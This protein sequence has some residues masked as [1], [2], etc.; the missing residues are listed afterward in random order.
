MGCMSGSNSRACPILYSDPRAFTSSTLVIDSW[1]CNKESASSCPDSHTSSSDKGPTNQAVS[2]MTASTAR[3]AIKTVTHDIAG[4]MNAKVPGAST[5][6]RAGSPKTRRQSRLVR[7]SWNW[8]SSTSLPTPSMQ[9]CAE[10]ASTC[11]YAT[12]SQVSAPDPA[13]TMYRL[14]WLIPAAASR[15]KSRPACSSPSSRRSHSGRGPALA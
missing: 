2:D 4:S 12:Q 9:C 14:R 7:M 5:K 13:G 10:A 6:R 1:S 11:L 8:G 3:A 15:P